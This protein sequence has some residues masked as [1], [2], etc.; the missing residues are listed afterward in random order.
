MASKKYTF[1]E[2]TTEF[3]SKTGQEAPVW[4]SPRYKEAKN[5]AIEIIESELYKGVLFESDF[6][7]LKNALKNG[8]ICYT[9]LVISHNGCLKINDV[10]PEGKRFDPDSVTIDKDGYG[11]SLVFIYKNA[12]QGV[13][14]V[15]E[16]NAKNC[17]NEYVYAMALKRCMDRVIL[18]LSKLGYIGFYSEFDTETVKA[19]E[20]D[21]TE[22]EKKAPE[23]KPEDLPEVRPVVEIPE[24]NN[25]RVVLVKFCK[26]NGINVNDVAKSYKLNNESSPEEFLKVIGIVIAKNEVVKFCRDHDINYTDVEKV[27]NL[28][29]ES[30]A[31]DFAKVLDILVKLNEEV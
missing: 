6:W 26:E 7:I 31:E 29:A 8:N 28:T 30:S 15:G 1:D 3:N 5:K 25:P 21:E 12:K 11:G 9:G 23:K 27:H 24:G 4:L 17:R 18:R 13:Y 14:E 10:L 2:K 20:R 19:P 22:T 16:A